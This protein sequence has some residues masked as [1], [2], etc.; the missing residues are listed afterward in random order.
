LQAAQSARKTTWEQLANSAEISELLIAINN[1][2][3][4]LGEFV[5]FLL[6]WLPHALILAD[7][8]FSIRGGGFLNGLIN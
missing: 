3:R 5:P 7:Q 4:W 1:V 6:K 8:I 2:G